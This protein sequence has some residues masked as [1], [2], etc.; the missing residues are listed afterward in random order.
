MKKYLPILL[1]A[2]I[3]LYYSC[4]SREE[5]N[6]TT[7]NSSINAINN[8]AAWSATLTDTL[9]NDTLT[10]HA[11]AKRYLLRMKFP[12]AGSSYNLMP[13]NAQ[14]FIFDNS[15]NVTNTFKLDATYPN[16]INSI[17]NNTV[18]SINKYFT[19]QF[20]SRFIIDSTGINTVTLA[21][22]TVT[23]TNGKFTAAYK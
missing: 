2:V 16:S 15:G 4:V 13:G 20:K 9:L 23:F 19:G 8:G 12:V 3:P 21:F 11:Q 10:L 18:S 6:Y 17:V 7:V 14:Y 22:D 5:A 1:F